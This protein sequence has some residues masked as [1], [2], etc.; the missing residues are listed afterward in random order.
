MQSLRLIPTVSK[1]L[2]FFLACQSSLLL[3]LIASSLPT[4]LYLT[5]GCDTII[6]FTLKIE[7]VLKITIFVLK[8]AVKSGPE[9][10]KLKS[11]IANKVRENNLSH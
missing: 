2:L 5:Y 9:E 7:P 1:H 10:T 11:S 4:A 8:M 3:S 6:V